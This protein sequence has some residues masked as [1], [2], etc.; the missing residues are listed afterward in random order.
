MTELNLTSYF[1]RIAYAGASEPTLGTLQAL[2]R[3]HP[4]AIT[5]ENLDPLMGRRVS[6]QLTVIVAKLIDQGRGGYCYEHNTL[7]ASVLRSLG[8]SVAALPARV[9]WG[10]PEGVVRPRTHMVLRVRCAEEDYLADVGFGRLTLTAP[11][12]WQPDIEQRTPHGLHRLMRVGDE[13]ELQI[14][15]A[16]HWAPIYQVSHQEQI[17]PDWEVANWFSST[18][19]D[20]IFT[21]SL[22]VARPVRDRI[23]AL[24][25]HRLSIHHA[26]GTVERHTAE[27]PSEIVSL[28]QGRFGMRLP[29]GCEGVIAR[30]AND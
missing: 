7:F 24:L 16:E 1:A 8:Y 2:H 22:I 13:I 17:A 27:R 19:P 18:H 30:L 9:K 21:H 12:R 14:R 11:L 5:F 23:Y 29:E 28:L 3:L 15:L 20:S 26:D 25:N 6:L 4:S 10:V